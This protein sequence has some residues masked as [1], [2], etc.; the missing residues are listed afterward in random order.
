M[1]CV[2]DKCDTFDATPHVCRWWDKCNDFIP[3][4]TEAKAEADGV[5]VRSNELLEEAERPE[6]LREECGQRA[7]GGSAASSNNN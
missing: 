1:K 4:P 7:I 6:T 2:N 5:G 3:S